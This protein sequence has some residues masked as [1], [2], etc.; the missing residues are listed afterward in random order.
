MFNTKKRFFKDKIDSVTKTIWEFEF[1]IQKSRQ[2]REGVRLDRDRAIEAIQ[3]ID[4]R[5][6]GETKEEEKAK[7]EVEKGKFQENVKRY[8]EQM[9]MMDKQ[10]TGFAWDETHEPIIGILE[11]IKS[12]VELREMYK[13]HISKM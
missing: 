5:I 7:M 3:Q 9:L 12:L 6:K 1:K 4:A 2:V 8:E 11:Q 13:D 10:I